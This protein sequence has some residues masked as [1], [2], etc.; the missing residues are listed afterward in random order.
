MPVLLIILLVAFLFF[1]GQGFQLTPQQ[2]GV[3][4]T[5]APVGGTQSAV[6]DETFNH[7]LD[8]INHGISATQT[9]AETI[10]DKY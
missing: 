7:L 8:T 5:A 9:V 2:A 3:P 4:Q 6:N 10:A 1:R